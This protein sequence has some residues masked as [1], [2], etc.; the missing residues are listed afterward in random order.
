MTAPTSCATTR[1]ATAR[2]R[3]TRPSA[4]SS[5]TTSR[6]PSTRRASL[7]RAMASRWM[8]V[9][10]APLWTNPEPPVGLVTK[11][12]APVA[13]VHGAADRFVPASDADELYELAGDPRR[14]QI[15]PA[16]GH[17]FGPE[18]V[19]AIR[20]AVQWALAQSV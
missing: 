19:P 9:Q 12:Q 1:A 15:V 7:G 8:G 6:R 2:P 14:L 20:G 5:V 3:G 4:I 17:A 13:F 16:M 11:V 10:V 18:S